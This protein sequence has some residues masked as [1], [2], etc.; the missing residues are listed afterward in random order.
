M[1]I[2]QSSSPSA[3][4]PYED[5][6][7]KFDAP[8][9]I[10]IFRRKYLFFVIP[11]LLV[12]STGFSVVMMQRPIYRSEGRILVV[13]PEIPPDL[14]KPT[15]TVVADERVQIIQQ[16]IMARDNLIGLINKYDLFPRQRSSMSESDLVDLVRSRTVI[17]PIEPD[18]EVLRRQNAPAI[19]FLLSF[20][21]EIPQ[22]A[23]NVANDFLT[24]ILRD[25]ATARANDAAATT[26]FIE[27]DV[28]RLQQEHDTVVAKLVA[29]QKQLTE[30]QAAPAAA[31]D[32]DD[33]PIE[34]DEVRTEKQHLSDLEVSLAQ[35]SSIYG[36]EHPVI[37]KLKKS[38]AELEEV[39]AA[40]PKPVARPH[41]KNDKTAQAPGIG[42]IA[43]VDFLVLERQEI[44][45]ERSLD[46]ANRKLNAAR[47][48]ESLERD[49][50]GERL[51]VIE[52]PSLPQA[53]VWPK[54]TKWLLF[55]FVAAFLGGVGCVIM[56]ESFDTTIRDGRELA[57]LVDRNLIVNIPYVATVAEGRERLRQLV[58]VSG[59][60]IAIVIVGISVLVAAGFPIDLSGAAHSGGGVLSRLLK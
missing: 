17:E 57:K 26:K 46:E 12:T 7:E 49:E 37:K 2:V 13:S 39:I 30:P 55:T 36:D 1:S 5:P 24:T 19:A 60:V 35:Q 23:M 58:F 14:V 18:A 34:S 56:A 41:R 10:R 45:L 27:R 53:P 6:G 8:Y 48:G 32:D 40:A 21:Y 3:F 31:V 42:S 44:D 33:T 15:I 11:F 16:R 38:I 29:M 43:N 22:I 59:A 47:L 50:Q 52:Q 4:I 9:L 20:D 54:R 25:D 28:K 51:T